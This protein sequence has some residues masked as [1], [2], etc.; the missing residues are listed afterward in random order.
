M[1]S[2]LCHYAC[3]V[4]GEHYR[5]AL[6]DGA[7]GA[8]HERETVAKPPLDRVAG[9]EELF[10]PCKTLYIM[11][12]GS[13]DEEEALRI[14]QHGRVVVDGVMDYSTRCFDGAVNLGSATDAA[15][16][17]A[18]CNACFTARATGTKA[19]SAGTTFWVPANAKPKNALERLALEIFKQHTKGCASFDPAASG[20]EWWTQVIDPQDDI[21]LHWDRDYDLE[22]A[23]GILL[24]PHIATVTYLNA[25]PGAAPTIVLE[26]PSPFLASDSPCGDVPSAVACW[27][28]QRRHLAFDGRLLHGAMSDLT[29]QQAAD[30][31]TQSKDAA[32]K[33]SGKATA[34]ARGKGVPEK[35]SKR[36]TFLV[37]CWLNHMPWGA[38]PLPK[39]ITKGLSALPSVKLSLGAKPTP[40]AR[41]SLRAQEFKGSSY[42]KSWTFGEAKAKLVLELPWGDFAKSHGSSVGTVLELQFEGQAKLRPKAATQASKSKKRSHA[43]V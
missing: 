43:C 6:H 35:S 12:D 27:P 37:N 8:L 2:V 16:V 5:G 40:L 31:G 41:Q 25:P 32:G 34:S 26:C 33:A 29:L 20:A 38:E 36:V 15:A 18:D 11:S 10:L 4:R 22:E 24:H 19:L 9:R 21:G 14:D 1:A 3:V 39:S 17:L 7:G 42:N 23:Q 28:E 30:S 13:D